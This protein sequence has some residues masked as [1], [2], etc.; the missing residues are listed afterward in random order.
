[1]VTIQDALATQ[2]LLCLVTEP[3]CGS[4]LAAFV[5]A[6]GG[7]PERAAKFL[8]QQLCTALTFS[9]ARGVY[10]QH[11]TPDRIFIDW[12]PGKLPLLKL[13]DC[14]F[15]SG[16]Q[17]RCLATYSTAGVSPRRCMP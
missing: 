17:V 9:H 4:T 7:L 5:E 13:G 8:F 15:I 3:I 12:S 10:V 16:A 1:M 11:L 6:K 2:K 14:G